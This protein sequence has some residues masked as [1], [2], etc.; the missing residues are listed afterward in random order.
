MKVGA[1]MSQPIVGS[2]PRE[3]STLHSRRARG[4]EGHG[5]TSWRASYS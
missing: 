4:T 2:D 1:E 3:S 5:M